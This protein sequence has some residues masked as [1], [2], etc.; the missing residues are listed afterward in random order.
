MKT[1]AIFLAALAALI[2]PVTINAQS[3]TGGE[4]PAGKQC[5]PGKKGKKGKARAHLKKMDTDGN[6]QISL[7]EAEAANAERLLENF[8]QID[9][10]GDGSINGEEMRAYGK[11]KRDERQAEREAEDSV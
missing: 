5:G 2:V 11:A 7:E 8:E 9:S 3:E 10:N 4:R 1:K 6:K